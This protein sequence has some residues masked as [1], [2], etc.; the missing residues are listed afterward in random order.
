MTDFE[1]AKLD[2]TLQDFIVR[3]FEKPEKCRNLDQIQYYLRELYLK[4]EEYDTRFNYVP[5]RA[6]A[7]VSQYTQMQKD[8]TFRRMCA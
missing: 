6:Y 2:S 5:K 7:L 8:F 4:I 3:N 1:K